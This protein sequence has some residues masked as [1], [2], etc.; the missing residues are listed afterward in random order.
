RSSIQYF[1]IEMV[2][3]RASAPNARTAVRAGFLSVAIVLGGAAC[4][5]Q[6]PVSPQLALSDARVGDTR[7]IREG[8]EIF[9]FDDFGNWRFWTDT[10]RLNDAVE[11]LTPNQALALG[12]KVDAE[13]VPSN[14]LQAVL[15]DPALL[16]DPATTRA[17]LGLN[18]VVGVVASVTGDQITRIGITCA[19]CHS[20]VDNSV[21]TGIG[22]RRDGWPNLDLRVGEIIAAAP[23]LPDA[24]RP[25]YA[26]WPAG[27]YDARFNFDGINGPVVI[28]PAYGLQGV[29]LETYTGEGPISYWNAYVAVTQMHGHGSF[30]DPRLGIE[31]V[32]PPAE[33]EV[34]SK[35]PALRRYQLSLAAPAP[36]TGSFD[37]AAAARGRV[38]FRTTARCSSCHT[39]PR[40][41]DDETLHAPAET[42]MEPVHAERSTTK[43][44][45]TTPLRAL[46]Q[47]APYFHDGSAASLEAVVA[48]YDTVLGLGLTAAQQV[49][50]VEYLKSL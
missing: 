27:F 13:A 20:T 11:T 39:G 17:L 3:R 18:A 1:M 38:V 50:L 37:A 5:D 28:P 2:A 36:P 34:K 48:H 31:I 19:L 21:T 33:D 15:A 9:R 35:L 43:L 46:W 4:V 32:V 42:G 45:R 6:E 16:D 8:R 10:L 47:H 24:V 12:L 22:S 40:F 44:Y 25:V 26:S 14:V 7:K 30:S 23:G 41:T 29:D 49:D